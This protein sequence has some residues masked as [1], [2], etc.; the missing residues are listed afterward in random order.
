M[1]TLIAATTLAILGSNAALAGPETTAALQA[2]SVPLSAEQIQVINTAHDEA[3]AQYLGTLAL[4]SPEYATTIIA[5]IIP[6]HPE[7]AGPIVAAMVTAVPEQTGAILD[8]AIAAAPDQAAELAMLVSEIEPTAA[9]GA[10][11]LSS[12]ATGVPSGSN[13]GT[14]SNNRTASPN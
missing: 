14:G 4:S 9:G 2:A 5:A 11:L 1:R 8:A 6:M 10:T 3:L 12:T 13:A 7:L